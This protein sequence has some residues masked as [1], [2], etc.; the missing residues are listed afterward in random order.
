[1]AYSVTPRR[2]LSRCGAA[3]AAPYVVSGSVLGGDG[4]KAPSERITG[5]VIGCGARAGTIR[6]AAG[7][8]VGVCD[9]WKDRRER[10]AR[11]FNPPPPYPPTPSRPPGPAP[12]SQI[13]YQ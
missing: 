9:P 2:F 6:S 8:L 1:M 12:L 10:W 13:S 3:I 5:A 7:Q 4:S 11:G